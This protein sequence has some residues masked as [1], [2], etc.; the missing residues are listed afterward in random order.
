MDAIFFVDRGLKPHLVPFINSVF[1]DGH[2][3]MEDND[4]KLTSNR[5][6]EYYK[7]LIW[8][9]IIILKYFY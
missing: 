1:P 4:V 2:L 3:F 8:K 9:T 7:E 5:A 6:K